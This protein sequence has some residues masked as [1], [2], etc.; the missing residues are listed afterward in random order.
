[1][2]AEAGSL[3]RI[4][5]EGMRSL[6]DSIKE[7]DGLPLMDFAIECQLPQT[8]QIVEGYESLESEELSWSQGEIINLHI[9]LEQTLVIAQDEKCN[10]FAIPLTYSGR[11]F[12]VN[13]KNRGK[14]SSTALGNTKKSKLKTLREIIDGSRLPVSVLIPRGEMEALNGNNKTPSVKLE[15]L[16]HL[17]EAVKQKTFLVSALIGSQ[18]RV[19]KLPMDV[20][21]S[22]RPE[23][24]KLSPAMFSHISHIIETEVKVESTI[25]CGS[26]GDVSWFFDLDEYIAIDDDV[27]AEIVPPVP[28]RQPSESDSNENV[29]RSK[30][31]DVRYTPCP[32][33]SYKPKISPKPPLKPGLKERQ[34]PPPAPKPKVLPRSDSREIENTLSENYECV[35]DEISSPEDGYYEDEYCEIAEV[36]SNIQTETEDESGMKAIEVKGPETVEASVKSNPV[37]PRNSGSNSRPTQERQQTADEVRERLQDMSV[38]DVSEYLKKLGLNKYVQSFKEEM[39]DGCMLMELDD[40]MMEQL[41]VQKLHRKKLLMFIKDG[42]TPRL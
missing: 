22:I 7:C 24:T 38:S 36:A 8:V 26:K 13:P 41:G 19:L 11:V 33:Q 34:P 6:K 14:V 32:G 31:L 23:K 10:D 2:F 5:A 4:E 35:D 16:F 28:P 12:D 20:E 42:Y 39:I 21:I 17:R 15:G 37:S 18:L 9:L 1:M 25:I 27:Y 3:S 29:H 30:E 40:E